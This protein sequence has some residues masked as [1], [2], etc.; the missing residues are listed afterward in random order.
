MTTKKTAKKQ[1][2]ETTFETLQTRYREAKAKA[3]EAGT[4]ARDA[5]A[6]LEAGRR[7]FGHKTPLEHLT[8]EEAAHEAAVA[9]LASIQAAAAYGEAL[10]AHEAEQGDP[11][12]RI[13]AELAPALEAQAFRVATLQKQTDEAKR[14]LGPIVQ[15]AI[16]AAHRLEAR[17]AAAGD[18]VPRRI[19]PM[20]GRAMLTL[21]T[22]A[23]NGTPTDDAGAERD[24][25]A[26]LD[27]NGGITIVQGAGSTPAER[28]A[29]LIAGTSRDA[30]DAKTRTDAIWRLEGRCDELRLDIA[31]QKRKEA[32]QAES[33][34]QWLAAKQAEREDEARRAAVRRAADQ[35][36]YAARQKEIEAARELTKNIQ[37]GVS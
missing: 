28:I 37:R 32:E 8:V 9:E 12:A 13:V 21:A 22:R 31:A 10:L 33:E 16:D 25:G 30:S 6:A 5:K 14:A 4:R 18:P 35:S 36:E 17:R 27:P 7:A 34:R 23:V 2:D 15:D 26:A 3:I 19:S 24:F 1:T 11:D 20:I 29:S